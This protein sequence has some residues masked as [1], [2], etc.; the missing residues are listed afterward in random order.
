MFVEVIK[1]VK[2]AKVVKQQHPQTLSHKKLVSEQIKIIKV[3]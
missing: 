3:S 1:T 2:L